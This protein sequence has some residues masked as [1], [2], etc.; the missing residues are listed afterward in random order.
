MFKV[1]GVDPS[2]RTVTFACGSDEQ[3]ME[4]TVVGS[5]SNFAWACCR[6]NLVTSLG[7]LSLLQIVGLDEIDQRRQSL[8]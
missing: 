5:V 7:N 3:A 8:P 1:E 4:K 2:G 6:N